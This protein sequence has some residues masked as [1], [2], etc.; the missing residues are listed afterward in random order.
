MQII[1]THAVIIPSILQNTDVLV[2]SPSEATVS[3]IAETWFSLVDA[4]VSPEQWEMSFADQVNE[5]SCRD[6]TANN[7]TNADARASSRRNHRIWLPN[8]MMANVF[9][10][11]WAFQIVCL[12]K[13]PRLES[14]FASI[15]DDDQWLTSQFRCDRIQDDVLEVSDKIRQSMAYLMQDE[16]KPRGQVSTFSLSRLHT[17]LP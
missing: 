1:L 4:L 13:I 5:P 9:T 6:Q 8:I 2:E 12:A 15:A 7:E 14:S 11:L 10:H 3:D 16:M 17:I